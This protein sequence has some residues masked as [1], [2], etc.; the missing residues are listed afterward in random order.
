M[1]T[2]QEFYDVC[3]RHVACRNGLRAIKG[4]TLAEWW[5]KTERGDWMLWLCGKR[6]GE[7]GWPTRQ[8]IVLAACDC[9]ELSLSLFEKKYPNDNRP[10]VAIETARK[11][12]NGDVGIKDVR[13]AAAAD[14]A[15]DN[16]AADDAAYAAAAAAYAAYAA[17]AYAA[18]DNAAYA[19]AD[20]AAAAYAADNAA[21]NAA[22]RTARLRECS[23][24]CRK[25]LEVPCGEQ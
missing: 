5:S 12:A 8:Q 21:D 6:Q 20:Y 10:R 1:K 3:V 13:S 7:K 23:E 17:A 11:W 15:A 18:A 25:R 9:A 16:A 14:N 24:I 19:A 4:L 22:A 2:A